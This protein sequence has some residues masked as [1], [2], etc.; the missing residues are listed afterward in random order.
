L[1]ETAKGKLIIFSAPSGAGKT[2]LVKY[3]M[4]QIS[5][6]RFSVSACTRQKRKGEVDGRD[7]YFL[8]PDAFRAKINNG[9]F[10]EWEEVYPDHYYG[11]LYHEVERLRNQGKHVVFDVDVVGGLNIKKQFKEDALAVFVRP[12][13]VKELEKRLTDRATDDAEKIKL[14][15]EKATYELS[16]EGSFDT[17]I[18]NDDLEQA[19]AEALERVSKFINNPVPSS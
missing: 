2:T 7:Y 4:E 3:L 8:K 11:T 13:S 16:F 9:E 14:R 19:K 17:V 6:L 15:I 18:I 5:S 10:V 1:T 12:P